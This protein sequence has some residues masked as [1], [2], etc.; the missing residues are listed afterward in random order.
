M[1]INLSAG[2]FVSFETLNWLD[3]NWPDVSHIYI[4]ADISVLNEHRCLDNLCQQNTF[5]DVF[6]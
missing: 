1:E 6:E 5:E 3:M 2:D 4:I